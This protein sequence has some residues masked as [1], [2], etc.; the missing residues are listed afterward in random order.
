MAGANPKDSCAT[1]T[2]RFLSFDDVERTSIQ[3]FQMNLG[4]LAHDEICVCCENSLISSGTEMKIFSGK[5]ETGEP[6]D[7]TIESMKDAT[8][9]YPMRY[10]YCFAGKVVAAGSSPVAQALLHERVFCFASHGEHAVVNAKDAFVIPQEISCSNAVLLPSVE[11]ALSLVQDAHPVLGDRI[12]VVGQGLI[13]LLTTAIASRICEVTAI[14]PLESR[15]EKA[16]LAGATHVRSPQQD[17]AEIINGSKHLDSDMDKYDILIEVSGHP[18]GLQFALDHTVFGG[19]I[20]LGSWYGDK[21]IGLTMGFPF[22]R[23]HVDIR[24]SQVSNIRAPLSARWNKKRRMKL[25]WQILSDLC[26]PCSSKETDGLMHSIVETK[27]YSLEDAQKAF[28]DLRDHNVITAGLK[29]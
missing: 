18:S 15:R 29:Y 8:M 26:N 14:D 12:A 9:S 25:A 22:H 28:E 11:T 21:P 4:S 3:N 16:I 7:M 17:T 24:A 1:T 19:V 10:G 23:S 2:S 27:F 20:I 5:F 13:G 6:V